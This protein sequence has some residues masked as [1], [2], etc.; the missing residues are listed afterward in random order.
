MLRT[1]WA[2]A[3]LES[4][5]TAC[6]GESSFPCRTC[7]LLSSSAVSGLRVLLVYVVWFGCASVNVCAVGSFFSCG[8]LPSCSVIANNGSLTA[9]Q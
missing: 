9:P 3:Q 7:D 6:R 5:S 8:V 1:S 2:I 4:A